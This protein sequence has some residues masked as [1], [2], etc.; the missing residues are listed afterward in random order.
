[1]GKTGQ[2]RKLPVMKVIGYHEGL[3]GALYE[4]KCSGSCDGE[5]G[6]KMEVHT[7]KCMYC[8]NPKMLISFRM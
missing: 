4:R 6:N 7:Y 1:M 2:D 3:C 8:V 5:E